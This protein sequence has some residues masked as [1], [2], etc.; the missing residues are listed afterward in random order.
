M[1]YVDTADDTG[2]D[3]QIKNGYLYWIAGVD[4]TFFEN[5]N[6]NLQFFQRRVRNYTDPESIADAA[7]RGI[8]LEN[9]ILDGQRDAIS[10]GISFRVSNQW[11]H[12][13]LEIE[14]FAAVNFTRDDSFLRPLVTYAFSDRWKGTIGA[15]IYRGARNTQ[16]GSLKPNRGAFAELRYGF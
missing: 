2:T 16:Y 5:L 1:V 7:S 6:I 12:E 15:E 3:P 10:N 4:R 14:L 13:T 8:A 11:L 9:A